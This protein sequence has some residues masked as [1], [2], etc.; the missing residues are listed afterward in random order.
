MPT[1]RYVTIPLDQAARA[2]AGTVWFGVWSPA[3]PVVRWSQHPAAIPAGGWGVALALD[4]A[5][6]RAVGG[7]ALG[8]GGK[9]LPPPLKIEGD[10]AAFHEAFEAWT[11]ARDA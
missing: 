4:T 9:D 3:A 6:T 10:L 2:P 11:V 8:T 5:E 1:Y 7:V